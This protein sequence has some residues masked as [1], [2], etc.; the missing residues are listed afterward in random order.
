M[1]CFPQISWNSPIAKLPIFLSSVMLSKKDPSTEKQTLY[2][3]RL[4]KVNLIDV[5]HQIGE[6]KRMCILTSKGSLVS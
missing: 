5:D 4:C 1:A 2:T 6:E 3:R